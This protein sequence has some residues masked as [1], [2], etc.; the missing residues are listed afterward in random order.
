VAGQSQCLA[1]KAAGSL[2]RASIEA[3]AIS[4]DDFTRSPGSVLDRL[5]AAA[6][7]FASTAMLM[8]GFIMAALFAADLLDMRRA[9]RLSFADAT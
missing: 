2:T 1:A 7:E 9:R 4:P 8:A 5:K 3:E 6:I